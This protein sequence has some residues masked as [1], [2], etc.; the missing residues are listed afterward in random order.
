MDTLH[1]KR[2]YY[3]VFA[4]TTILLEKRTTF[5]TRFGKHFA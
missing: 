2:L 3:Y 1:K 5:K 4:K